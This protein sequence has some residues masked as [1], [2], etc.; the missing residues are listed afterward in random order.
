MMDTN[1]WPECFRSFPKFQ[2]DSLI[3]P[4]VDRIFKNPSNQTFLPSVQAYHSRININK[5]MYLSDENK[6]KI[7]LFGQD[8]KLY[9]INVHA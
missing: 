8:R 2:W 3:S 9:A 4:F 5:G 6:N 7:K 1:S